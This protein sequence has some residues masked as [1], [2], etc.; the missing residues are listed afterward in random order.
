MSYVFLIRARRRRCSPISGLH[1]ARCIFICVSFGLVWA[2]P[3]KLGR[4][5]LSG[6]P[7]PPYKELAE[8]GF[9]EFRSLVSVKRL[10]SGVPPCIIP[11][12][13]A[14]PCY[15]IYIAARVLA[16]I[17]N[18]RAQVRGVMIFITLLAG[19]FLIFRWRL[20]ALLG[21]SLSGGFAVKDRA[22]I[23]G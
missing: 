17:E 9:R 13:T 22:T 5:P 11:P 7:Q 20:L 21:D 6:A 15:P 16:F 1:Q 19:L 10:S 12:G 18:Y 2:C 8:L 3:T 23:L 4:G 14:L